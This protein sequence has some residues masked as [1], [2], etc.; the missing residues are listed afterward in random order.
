VK[1]AVKFRGQ[2]DPCPMKLRKASGG[3]TVTTPNYR[4]V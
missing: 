4:W 2:L 1:P 3:Q